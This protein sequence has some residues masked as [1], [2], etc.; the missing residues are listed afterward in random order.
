[1]TSCVL[2]I[3]P[4]KTNV[5]VENNG[6]QSSIFTTSIHSPEELLAC[7]EKW[8]AT[9]KI[10]AY[11]ILEHDRVLIKAWDGK[12]RIFK[13]GLFL[14]AN[15]RFTTCPSLEEGSDAYGA[16]TIDFYS[17]QFC[18]QQLVENVENNSSNKKRVFRK[19]LP[20]QVQQS[21]LFWQSSESFLTKIEQINS[22]VQPYVLKIEGGFM[23]VTPESQNL[24]DFDKIR[25]NGFYLDLRG[26]LTS[27]Q[28]ITL[29]SSDSNEI[30][31]RRTVLDFDELNSA[32]NSLKTMGLISGWDF[33]GTRGQGLFAN[34]IVYNFLGKNRKFMS[35]LC[36]WPTDEKIEQSVIR[37]YVDGMQRLNFGF[38][39][40]TG[41]RQEFVEV[42]ITYSTCSQGYGFIFRSKHI[43][44]KNEET[45]IHIT[46]L[47]DLNI[48]MRKQI[49]IRIK[50][51]FR[52]I[53]SFSGSVRVQ[54]SRTCV[55]KRH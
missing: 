2:Q 34:V 29:L 48:F 19:V 4:D 20:K 51:E 31:F 35:S 37:F 15:D 14:V 43:K 27:D 28:T 45:I 54:R 7:L 32:L 33:D 17:K 41:W 1:M 5:L 9:K 13:A 26:P 53:L 49:N 3:Q 6:L 38:V 21:E 30:V 25:I 10:G 8:R 55:A 12:D 47:I 40:K 11:R 18:V 16:K 23:A 42:P 50:E 52:I 46:V 44:I 39:T 24:T 22:P 36:I